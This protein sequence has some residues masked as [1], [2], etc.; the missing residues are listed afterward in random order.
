MQGRELSGSL[1]QASRVSEMLCV[2]VDL[3]EYSVVL[4]RQIRGYG[5]VGE[6]VVARELLTKTV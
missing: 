5:N 2:T 1:E 6:H 4:Q 3:L